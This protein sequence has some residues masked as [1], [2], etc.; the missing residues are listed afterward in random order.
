MR[1][2]VLGAGYVGLSYAVLLSLKHNVIIYDIDNSKIEKIRNKK[3]PFYDEQIEYFLKQ[4]KLNLKTTYNQREAI[5]T[6][7]IIIIAVCTN[8]DEINKELNTRIINNIIKEIYDTNSNAIILI[9]STIPIGYTESIRKKFKDIKI[10]YSPEF[11]SEG[12]ALEYAFNPD[13]IVIGDQSEL[14]KKIYDMLKSSIKINKHNVMFVS[15]YEA[16]CIKLFSNAYLA[17][18]VAFFNEIDSFM[19]IN[20]QKSQNVITGVCLDKRIGNF[21]NN[22]SFGYGGYCLP[23]DTKQ[24]I[25]SMKNTPNE[26]ISAINRSNLKRIEHISKSIMKKNK[27]IIGIYRINAK[28]DSDNLRDSSTIQV[29]NLL[30]NKGFEVIIYE[31]ILN[32]YKYS[33]CKIINNINDFINQVDLIVANRISDCLKTANKPV[34]TRDIFEF[35]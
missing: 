27:K 28:K 16:E 13:R 6:S 14:G 23:K 25:T 11:L 19:E 5:E 1:I 31:P 24:L 3:S 33:G 22:P 9:K 34:Y 4:K 2:S 26:L 7:E 35:L 29:I 32:D 21:Y 15:S 10:L 17:M 8:Y 18:R 12:D 20:G 30:K